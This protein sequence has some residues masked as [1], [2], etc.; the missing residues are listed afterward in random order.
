MKIYMI[1]AAA[2]MLV[3]T[4][5]MSQ[6]VANGEKEFRKCKACHMI[7]DAGGT[8]IVKGGAVGPNLW[9][10]VGR[11]VASLEGYS[12]GPGIVE[13]AGANPDMVWSAEELTTYVTD[14]GAWVKEKSGDAGARSKMT[15][16][17]NKNQA[18][19]VAYLASV[20]PDAPAE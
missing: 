9:N 3:A 5:A 2:L 16:K 10:V 1:T 19:L 15:F 20:S 8:D 6:D 12:Y 4:Q 17:L 7:R 13:A 14:P 18:D 11:K